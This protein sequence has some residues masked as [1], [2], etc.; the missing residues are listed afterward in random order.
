MILCPDAKETYLFLTERQAACASSTEK[1]SIQ[2]YPLTPLYLPSWK[3]MTLFFLRGVTV[4]L[5]YPW[6]FI[7]LYNRNEKWSV[8]VKDLWHRLTFTVGDSTFLPSCKKKVNVQVRTNELFTCR[9]PQFTY[10]CMETCSLFIINLPFFLWMP[11]FI[12][13][14][15]VYWMRWVQPAVSYSRH[16]FCLKGYSI[17]L[18][19]SAL[20]RNLQ[21]WLEAKHA[22]QQLLVCPLICLVFSSGL[23]TKSTETRRSIAGLTYFWTSKPASES[24]VCQSLKQIWCWI[25]TDH[26]KYAHCICY[27][28]NSWW[29]DW[30]Y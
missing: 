4:C 5:K 2:K 14:L 27:W 18:W 11:K 24:T 8:G 1:H 7:I 3:K 28:V 17:E 12:N 22:E 16:S 29:L 15:M 10:L 6:H 20:E 25:K 26:I 9:I 13:I 23:T 30:Q 21:H 19:L